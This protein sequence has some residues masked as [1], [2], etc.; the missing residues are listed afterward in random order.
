MIDIMRKSIK[1][2]R[3]GNFKMRL[4]SVKDKLPFLAAAGHN[5]YTKSSWLYRQQL[6][7]L[8]VTHPDVFDNFSTGRY[9]V[10][11]T[12]FFFFFLGGGGGGG[13]YCFHGAS[14]RICDNYLSLGNTPNNVLP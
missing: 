2:E 4:E 7:D 9:A 5:H 8:K 6:L 10:R 13:E 12:D 3:T 11:R 14:Q 1:A